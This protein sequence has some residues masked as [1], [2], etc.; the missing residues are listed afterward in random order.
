MQ[1]IQ[2]TQQLNKMLPEFIRLYTEGNGLKEVARLTN[3]PVDCIRTRLKKA[4]ILRGKSATR[5][6]MNAVKLSVDYFK[7]IDTTDK[8]YWLGYITAD[9]S[10]SN[11][12]YKVSLTSKDQDVIF[13]FKNAV[14][15]GHAISTIHQK[16]KRTGK[17]YTRWLI[18]ICSKE[19]TR[20]LINQGVSSN[21]STD[22][23]LPDLNDDLF[24]HYLR[25]LFDG[26]GSITSSKTKTRISFI[27]TE[28]LLKGIQQRLNQLLGVPERPLFSISKSYPMYRMH[29]YKDSA[30][31]LDSMYK[32]SL[33]EI[34]LERKLKIYKHGKTTTC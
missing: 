13:R 25:G 20:Y 21:K 27:G 5:Q 24:Y 1:N 30:T 4:G 12:G 16:D 7:I 18:Q 29:Y 3:T 31:I 32:N 23:C 15:S 19:F 10:I 28:C 26:D 34:R 17:T 11:T 9:G 6:N 14:E 2:R 33:P 8:A 22:L